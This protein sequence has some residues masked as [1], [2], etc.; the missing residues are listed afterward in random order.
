[1]RS[2]SP[3]AL[4]DKTRGVFAVFFGLLAVILPDWLHGWR[5]FGAIFLVVFGTGD[6]FGM[7]MVAF[8]RR[9]VV[10]YIREH[11]C[12]IESAV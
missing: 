9:K 7:I 5:Q 12:E 6:L 8:Y 4:A 2:S 10:H 1:M 11:G 3:N